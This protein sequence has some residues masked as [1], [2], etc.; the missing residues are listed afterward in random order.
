MLDA[1]AGRGSLAGVRLVWTEVKHLLPFVVFGVDVPRQEQ[2]L[3]NID[4]VIFLFCFECI[5]YSS[6][7]DKHLE[8]LSHEVP[9]D[10]TL[11]SSPRIS[12][13]RD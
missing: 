3:S 13:A 11:K 9:F 8:A 5:G 6:R 4:F 1:T 2:C 12:R 10:W 7:H